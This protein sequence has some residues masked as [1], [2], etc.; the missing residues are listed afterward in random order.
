MHSFDVTL[1]MSASTVDKMVTTN[2]VFSVFSFEEFWW[3]FKVLQAAR[4]G[5]F[6]KDS[7]FC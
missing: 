5:P 6:S 3:P 2:V 1:R 4:V 7:R